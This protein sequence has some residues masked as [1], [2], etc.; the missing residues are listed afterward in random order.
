MCAYKVKK[1]NNF[2]S[3]SFSVDSSH[4]VVG[5]ILCTS[6]CLSTVI[7]IVFKF[8][9]VVFMGSL[10]TQSHCLNVKRA[11]KYSN[12]R[13][14]AECMQMVRLQNFKACKLQPNLLFFC[15]IMLLALLLF[16][17]YHICILNTELRSNLAFMN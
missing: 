13:Q 7:Q 2:L 12:V 17:L 4:F 15:L 6:R 8:A 5:T 14:R 16:L 9:G 11:E 10:I 3:L 1:T